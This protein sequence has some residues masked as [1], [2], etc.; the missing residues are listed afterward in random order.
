MNVIFFAHPDF[1]GSQSMPRFT[2]MLAEGM[3]KRNWN[4]TIMKPKASVSSLPLPQIFKKWLGYFVQ[5]VLFPIRIRQILKKASADT[6]FVFTDHALGP[7]IPILAHKPHVI[8]CHDFLAQKSAVGLLTAN[9][10][11]WSGRLYQRYIRRGF[12]AGENFISISKKTHDDL[13]T[14]LPRKPLRSEVVYNGLN[15]SFKVA[16]QAS[17]RTRLGEH[18]RASMSEGYLLHVGGNQWYKNRIGV[19][20][21]Y[22]AWRTESGKALPLIMAGKS[23]DEKLRRAYN[24]SHFKNDIYWLEHPSDE[25]LSEAYAG[26]T[27]LLF[28]S[29]AEGFGWPIAEAMACGCPVITTNEAPMSEVAGNAGF[30]LP[31]MPHDP[32]QRFLWL[33]QAVIVIDE[34][35]RLNDDERQRVKVIGELNI[36][37]FNAEM[38]LDKINAI[39][40]EI[41]FPDLKC[42]ETHQDGSFRQDHNGGDTH[43]TLIE[44]RV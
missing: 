1:L 13:V 7:W 38:F 9:R 28:P 10:T 37:R 31:V 35:V 29:L 33:M 4:V 24:E 40:K 22:N 18:F 19:I 16:D 14:F 8:H 15:R 25:I 2:N 11:A 17:A 20:L 26:A 44:T 41:L 42:T 27:A 5:Y 6:L 39:Y 21:M 12:S 43:E 23:P 32:A 30:L 3:R 36:Q 34:V